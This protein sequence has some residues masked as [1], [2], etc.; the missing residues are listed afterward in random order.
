MFLSKKKKSKHLLEA[1]GNG[2]N[3]TV[4][5]LLSKGADVNAMSET[6]CMGLNT[7]LTPLMYAARNGHKDLV[8]VLLNNGAEVN[9]KSNNGRSA[10]MLAKLYGYTDIVEMLKQAGAV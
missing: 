10:L 1:S 5:A 9:T 6:E 2:D 3:D 4:I 8:E 7:L